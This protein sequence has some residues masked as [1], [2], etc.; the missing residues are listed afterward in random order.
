MRK[1]L[2]LL[3]LLGACSR[4][5][6][7]LKKNSVVVEGQAACAASEDCRAAAERAAVARAAALYLPPAKAES[8]EVDKAVLSRAGDFIKRKRLI[9][10]KEAGGRRSVTIRA[11]VPAVPLAGAF[12][13][14]GLLKPEG[15][16]GKPKIFISLKES[17]PG[18]GVEVGQ[19]SDALRR[20][21]SARGYSA[22][23]FSDRLGQR[24]QRKG[25]P[26]E[27]REEG[28]R[29]GADAVLHGTARAAPAQEDRLEGFSRWQ[30]VIR[31]TLELGSVDMPVNVQA[32]AVDVSPAGAAAKALENAGM[33]AGEGL[34]DALA[35]RFKERV[36]L[37]L[38]VAGLD[39]PD[40]AGRFLT[41]L[42]AVPGV[43]AAAPAKLGPEI[44]L[45]RVFAERMGAEDL[46]ALL[47]QLKGFSLEV[48]G[49]D[50]AARSLD[51]EVRG[52]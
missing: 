52:G 15:V 25:T 24:V 4:L 34:G 48:R 26:E 41:A 23:D 28:K 11:E 18:S 14:L 29:Q 49:V 50:P 7:G 40:Q 45:I 21:L 5:Q 3:L 36:E 31:A 6:V 43:V 51:V 33:L 47:I 8:P 2:P 37:G 38:F 44:V 42:R 20:A 17:G 19:A 12:D 22:L 30:A 27:A 46:A 13:A 9:E 39:R 32:D 35:G 10:D 16:V 1:L